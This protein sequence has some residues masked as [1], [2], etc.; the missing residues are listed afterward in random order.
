MG[1]YFTSFKRQRLNPLA[2][3]FDKQRVNLIPII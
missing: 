2:Y 3:T 1:P